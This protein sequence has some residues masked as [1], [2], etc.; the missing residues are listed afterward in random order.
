MTTSSESVVKPFLNQ[1][2]NK[3]VGCA[4]APPALVRKRTLHYFNHEVEME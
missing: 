4:C 2:Y 3:F 1:N